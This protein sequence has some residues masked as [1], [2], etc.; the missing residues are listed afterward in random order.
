[1]QVWLKSA[2]WKRQHDN[3]NCQADAYTDQQWGPNSSPSV[4]GVGVGV[5]GEAYLLLRAVVGVATAPLIEVLLGTDLPP[6]KTDFFKANF[7]LQA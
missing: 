2:G 7:I 4:G 1:M 6:F 3:T 5:G